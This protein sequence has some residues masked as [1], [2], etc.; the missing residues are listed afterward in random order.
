[1]NRFTSF[2]ICTIVLMF[3]FGCEPEAVQSKQDSLQTITNTSSASADNSSGASVDSSEGDLTSDSS[4]DVTSD[5][6]GSSSTGTSSESSS[7]FSTESSSGSS[8]ESSSDSI[9]E[10]SSVSSTESSSDFSDSSSETP[11]LPPVYSLEQ[12]EL[13]SV[14][15]ILTAKTD[16]PDGTEF[17]VELNNQTITDK[18]YQ[19]SI[20]FNVS[21]CFDPIYDGGGKDYPAKFSCTEGDVSQTDFSLPYWPKLYCELQCDDVVKVWN[22]CTENFVEPIFYSN[23]K[24]EDV[25]ID[26]WI[27][28]YDKDDNQINTQNNISFEDI[29]SYLSDKAH[30]DTVVNY[31]GKVTPIRNNIPQDNLAETLEVV[32]LCC[33]DVLVTNATIEKF[34]NQY[35]AIGYDATGDVAGGKIQYEWQIADSADAADSDWVDLNENMP[36]H[37][38]AESE[39][40]KYLRV[41]LT[42][43]Y[44]DEIQEPIKTQAILVKNMFKFDELHLKYNDVLLSGSKPSVDYLTGSAVNIFD[45]EVSDFTLS[46]MENQYRDGMPYSD[47]MSV[48]IQKDGYDDLSADVFITVKSDM[49]NDEV[50]SLSTNVSNITLGKV[51]FEVTDTR[52]ECSF[53]GGLSWQNMPDGE[54]DTTFDSNI[55]IRKKSYG[56]PN[57][58]GYLM[59]SDP[60]TITVQTANIGIQT[61]MSGINAEIVEPELV[62]SKTE[63]DGQILITAVPKGFVKLVGIEWREQYIWSI[64][65]DTVDNEIDFA[66]VNNNIM[67]LDKSKLWS[68]ETYQVALRFRGYYIINDEEQEAIKLSN[69]IS[70]KVE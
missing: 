53:D 57:V 70:I 39:I 4:V 51:K 45:K 46:F 31:L 33:E 24:I 14:S 61:E 42:Q 21:P 40:G 63:N 29:L 25:T 52:I 13:D 49:S 17:N 12:V 5:S 54:F 1:M 6:S 19:G 59:E 48:I 18:V 44:C 67:Y 26:E 34:Y 22:G 50:P 47:Y 65:G 9:T 15:Y 32:Y 43:N 11:P 35:K 36:N 28:I 68:G 41:V 23:Y 3:L 56:Q 30:A 62:L 27:V 2:M 64:D 58:T 55:L 69:Q 38:A 60:R 20:E 66:D 37:S 16:A 8:T 7:G 10:S